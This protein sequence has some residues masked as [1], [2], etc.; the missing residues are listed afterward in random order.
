MVHS[1]FH[2]IVAHTHSS[3]HQFTTHLILFSFVSLRA[4]IAET[5]A[6]TAA[7]KKLLAQLPSANYM[8]LAMLVVHMLH[9]IANVLIPRPNMI[10]CLN[11]SVYS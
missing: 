4:G 7:L 2:L 5:Q 11:V 10:H 9:V 3:P 8:T 6:R 1:L